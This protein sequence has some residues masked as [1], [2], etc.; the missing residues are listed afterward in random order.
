[1]EV[2][3]ELINRGRVLGNFYYVNIQLE[4]TDS[5]TY[6]GNLETKDIE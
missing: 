6:A 4:I 1:M 3:N 2:M 5:L